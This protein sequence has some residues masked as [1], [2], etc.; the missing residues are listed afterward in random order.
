MMRAVLKAYG[1]EDR[2]IWVADSFCGLPE[3]NPQIAAD[4]GDMHHTFSELVISQDQVEANFAK[5]GLLDDQIRFLKGWLSETLPS[6]PIEKLAVLRLDGDMYES[7]MDAL[8]N[9]YDKVSDGGFIIVTIL[10]LC[11][12]VRRRCLISVI[13]EA[14]KHRSNRSTGGVFSGE[15]EKTALLPFHQR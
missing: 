13:P 14:L 7:T 6:A 11:P 8:M 3:P 15:R 9:L 12:D 10:A 5:Y 1:V 2:C 4:A